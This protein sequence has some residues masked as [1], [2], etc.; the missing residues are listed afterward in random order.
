[1]MPRRKLLQR[2]F[3]CV[4][5]VLLAGGCAAGNGKMPPPA[6]GDEAFRGGPMLEYFKAA[7][8]GKEVI[9]LDKADLNSDNTEDMVVIFRESKETN[10]MLVV[11]DL[12]GSYQCTN[13]VPAPVSNQV[14]QFKDI[15]QKP[16]LEFIVQ[17]MKGAN[18]GYAIYRV[19]GTKL[20]DL[21]GEGMKDCC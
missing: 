1:M 15:D 20:E 16:P 9:I 2:F 14:I 13:K 11:L 18:V 8:P 4:V 21:F 17:G 3:A 7:H 10:S 6:A 12:S 5:L 19:E